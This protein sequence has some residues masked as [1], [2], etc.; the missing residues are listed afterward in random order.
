MSL[1]I[2]CYPVSGVDHVKLLIVSASPWQGHNVI[3]LANHQTEAD[4]A[5]MALLL[6]HSHPY[7]AENLVSLRE[8]DDNTRFKTHASLLW[9]E[10]LVWYPTSVR[11]MWLETGLCWTHSASLLVWAGKS[12]FPPNDGS[13][14]SVLL[15]VVS[16]CSRSFGSLSSTSRCV[17]LYV[18]TRLNLSLITWVADRT[19]L[20][21]QKSFVRVFEKTYKRCTGPCWD[22]NQS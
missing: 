13:H 6:E 10:Y 11:P 4:P 16:N 7:L 18:L 5:V 8:F 19:C 22:E 15:R 14:Y 1:L 12:L 2:V 21:I 3:L 9:L 17:E 20:L